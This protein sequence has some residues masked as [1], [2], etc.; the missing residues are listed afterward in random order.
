[1]Q[2]RILNR[3]YLNDLEVEVNQYIKDGWQPHGGVMAYSYEFASIT[4]DYEYVSS[5]GQTHI[6]NNFCQ[7]MVKGDRRE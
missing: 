6:K 4:K 2:Y 1:M 7:A 3:E 5:G